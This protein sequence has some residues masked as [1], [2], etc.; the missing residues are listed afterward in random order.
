MYCNVNQCNV[1]LCP[2]IMASYL[3]WY[4]ILCY[5]MYV[6]TVLSTV[7]CSCD[8]SVEELKIWQRQ[9]HNY[10]CR[11]MVPLGTQGIFSWGFV[12][13]ICCCFVYVNFWL[14]QVIDRFASFSLW[15]FV[16]WHWTSSDMDTFEVTA[17]WRTVH[18]PIVSVDPVKQERSSDEC[19]L[20]RFTTDCCSRCHTQTENSLA[21][22]RV[23]MP[24]SAFALHAAFAKSEASLDLAHCMAA[25]AARFQCVLFS[26]AASRTQSRRE[27]R[28]LQPHAG[29]VCRSWRFF[30]RWA[31]LPPAG[32]SWLSCL[33]QLLKSFP[34]KQHAI[35]SQ[36]HATS[37]WLS[38]ELHLPTSG[39]FTFKK[40]KSFCIFFF[41]CRYSISSANKQ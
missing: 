27:N 18:V 25:I 35:F 20:P 37:P 40:P 36:F 39:W 34:F 24:R 7:I 15:R 32:V 5:V 11:L 14:V 10:C 13:S 2:D 6:H 30:G 29:R 31:H 12:S 21:V 41:H 9:M 4:V 17:T 26:A 16:H 8:V 28:A 19:W 23:A 22:T 33:A 38:S 1:M 3:I